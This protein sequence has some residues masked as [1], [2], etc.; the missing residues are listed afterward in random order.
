MSFFVP[1]FKIKPK[2]FL[3]ISAQLTLGQRTLI[4]EESYPELPFHQINLSY[5]EA[6]QSLKIVLASAAA[7]KNEL[8][9]LLPQIKLN[10][11]GLTLTFIPFTN[12]GYGLYQ[13]HCRV[14]I[15]R[16]VLKHGRAL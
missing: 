15:N 4:I 14:N 12:S 8:I 3:R 9:P 16:Q 5:S 1:A 10:V 7:N 13:E 6:V 2:D 11:R